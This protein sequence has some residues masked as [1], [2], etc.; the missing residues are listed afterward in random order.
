MDWPLHLPIDM[1]AA[2]GK[3]R[4][5]ISDSFVLLRQTLFY[6]EPPGTSVI[7]YDYL[8]EYSKAISPRVV[9]L[10]TLIRR[11]SVFISS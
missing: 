5:K 8:V 11:L 4:E 9:I 10:A 6:Y 1:R 2:E 7:F 3:E